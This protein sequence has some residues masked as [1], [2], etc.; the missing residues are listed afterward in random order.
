VNDLAS[1]FAVS[2]VRRLADP[3]VLVRGLGSADEGRVV[4]LDV[5]P[6]R[7]SATVR[8]SV[9]YDVELHAERGA[10]AWSCTS[11]YAERWAVSR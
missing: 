2:A 1:A 6:H 11:P 4:D 10:P 8:G 3:L 7:A 9:P 5:G